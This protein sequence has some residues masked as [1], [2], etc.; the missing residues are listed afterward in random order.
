MI[1][2]K[3]TINSAAKPID[4]LLFDLKWLIL[5]FIVRFILFKIR[6]VSFYFGYHES[7]ERNKIPSSQK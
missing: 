1:F 7:V 5:S 2:R 4:L 3:Y 6:E